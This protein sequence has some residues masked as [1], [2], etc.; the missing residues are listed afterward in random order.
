M[1]TATPGPPPCPD[2]GAPLTGASTC[3]SCGLRLTGPEAVRLWEVDQE[4]SA[5][6]A[7]RGKLLAERMRLVAAL[8]P[9]TVVSPAPIQP[10]ATSS[11]GTATQ[12]WAP[13]PATVPTP[14]W[15]SP[16]TQPRQ[17]WTPQ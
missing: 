8:R 12:T 4:L 7:H 2:C 9:G 14:V 3:A 10:T 16:V 6:D 1:T 15:Q 11:P 5:L 13:P 17:E